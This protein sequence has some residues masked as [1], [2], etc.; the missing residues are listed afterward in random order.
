MYTVGSENDNWNEL[1]DKFCLEFFP[2]SRVVSLERDIRCFQQNERESISAAWCRFLSFIESGPVL[3][4]PE[5]LLHCNFYEGLS[6]DYAYY[7]DVI[8]GGSFLHMSLA[9]CREILDS[10]IK[11]TTF[12]TKPKSFREDRKSSQED[13]LA[14]ESNSSPSTSSDSAIE[15]STKSETSEEGE[16][17]PLKFPSQF[18][19]DPSGNHRNTSN[20]FDAQLGEEPSSVH[21]DPSRIPLI[22]LFLRPTVPFSHPDPLNKAILK[23]A[24]KEEW[25]DV[26]VRCFSKAFELVHPLR[27]FLAL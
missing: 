25:S 2:L 23:E 5:S 9:E 4:I 21:T 11:C 3:S 14:T 1:K 24:I 10:I 7:F 27:S 22:E 19:D 15:P 20:F 13:L 16:I 26:V 8:A 12:T 18:E 17:Q 6:K